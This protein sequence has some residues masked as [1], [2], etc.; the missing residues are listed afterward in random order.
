[1]AKALQKI[2]GI[3]EQSHSTNPLRLSAALSNGKQIWAFRYLTD[4]QSPSLYFGCPHTH[5]EVSN[6]PA[7]AINLNQLTTTPSKPFD[8]DGDHWTQVEEGKVVFGD[9]GKVQVEDL[10]II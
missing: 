1:M 9:Q 4:K 3:L 8:D 5:H 6:R 10:P 7:N 2:A